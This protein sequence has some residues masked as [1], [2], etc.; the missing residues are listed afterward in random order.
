MPSR[1]RLDPV[2]ES[3]VTR[4]AR[5]ARILVAGKSAHNIANQSGGWTLTWQGTGNWN[6]DFPGATSIYDGIKA[7]APSADLSYNLT[8]VDLD[9]S[10]LGRM[11]ID[12]RSR[13]FRRDVVP[14]DQ[15]TGSSRIQRC[16]AIAVG[17]GRQ[18]GKGIPALQS[19]ERAARL[20][21][22][23]VEALRYQ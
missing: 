21:L 18:S 1:R 19:G 12:I 5:D 14:P 22:D 10:V 23:P 7:V 6:G 8:G 9:I 4:L 13:K 16:D 3:I 11:E 20:L 15:C 17:S 2:D